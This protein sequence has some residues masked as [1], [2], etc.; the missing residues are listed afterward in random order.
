MDDWTSYSISGAHLV[1]LLERLRPEL[2]E[3]QVGEPR[4]DLVRAE[5]VLPLVEQPVEHPLRQ[6]AHEQVALHR[7]VQVRLEAL[8]LQEDKGAL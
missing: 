4:G 2:D 3:P 1:L 8:H 6:A 5:D 7:V